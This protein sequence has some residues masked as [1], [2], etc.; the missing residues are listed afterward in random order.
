MKSSITI[1]PIY[2]LTALS[3]IQAVAQEGN[4]NIITDRPSQTESAYLVPAG[5]LQLE[6][7]FVAENDGSTTNYTYNVSSFRYGVNEHFELRLITEYRG[8][9]SIVSGEEIVVN[10]MAPLILGTKLKI[11]DNQGWIPQAAFVGHIVLKTGEAEFQPDFVSSNFRFTWE[12]SLSSQFSLGGNL[13]ARWD[14]YTPNATGVYTLIVGFGLTERI[15]LF[16]E[17]YG[18]LTEQAGVPDH[19]FD[20]GA[21]YRISSNM[22]FDISGGVGISD[23]S[24]DNYLSAGFSIRFAD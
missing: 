17:V 3:C 8:N 5:I 2:I 16:T 11:S 23:I 18:F 6:T 10:G 9:K 4:G 12:Y 24:P 1:F 19:R 13:G 15:A 7:G 22:Q 21:T 14:G 20:A